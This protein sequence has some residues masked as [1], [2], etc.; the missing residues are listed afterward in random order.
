MT[1][2][3]LNP[4]CSTITFEDWCA[5]LPRWILKSRTKFSWFLKRSFN[6][7]RQDQ[8]CL[9][10]TVFPLPS[11]GVECFSG[12]GPKLKKKQWL[13]VCRARV[14][15]IVVFSL[16]YLYLG[17]FPSNEELGRQANERQKRVFARLSSHLAVCG[18]AREEFPLAPGRSGPKLAQCLMQLEGFL[19]SC[20]AFE[21]SYFGAFAEEPYVED[22]SLLPLDEFPQ[23]YPT[24]IFVLIAFALS[25][26]EI[27]LLRNTLMVVFGSP[28]KSQ[29]F[30]VMGYPLKVH[31]C[32]RS[33]KKIRA[34]ASSSQNSG[35]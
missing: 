28:T 29:L 22:P 30:F 8:K 35:M 25:V 13:R 3:G 5:S 34:N 11:P 31:S 6:A 1:L 16:N 14:L 12:G 19:A 2:P 27:G 23:L 10:T 17:R 4:L 9:P 18:E 32:L 21:S 20:S 7:V 24:E 15:H 33:R 26:E